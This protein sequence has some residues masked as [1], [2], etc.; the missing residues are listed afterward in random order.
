MTPERDPRRIH[1]FV[2]DELDLDARLAMEARVAADPA[3]AATVDDLRDLRAQVREHATH[4]AAPDALRA[5]LLG[6]RGSPSPRSAPDWRAWFAWRPAVA[7]LAAVALVA[8]GVQFVWLPARHEDGLADQV[9]ASHVR[10]TLG[11]HLLDVASSDRHVVK[12]WLSSKLDFSPPVG[13]GPVGGATFAG[14]RVDYLDGHPVA[15]LVYQHGRHVTEVYVWPDR[16]SD[17]SAK[18][19]ADR[20]FRMARWSRNGMSYWAISDVNAQAFEAFVKALP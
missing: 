4:H 19:F 18:F 17:R 11:E 3:L 9:V 16:A 6:R 1:A 12:P 7:T 15:A 10:S 5:A 20:G 13:D 14:G 8:I 2:D